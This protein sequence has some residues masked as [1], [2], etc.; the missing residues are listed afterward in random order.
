[1]SDR[2]KSNSML[3]KFKNHVP[4]RQS[5]KLK[6]HRECRDNRWK[7]ALVFHWFNFF[8]L[9][10][11]LTDR[12]NSTENHDEIKMIIFFHCDLRQPTLISKIKMMLCYLASSCRVTSMLSV[13]VQ[14]YSARSASITHG[15]CFGKSCG[16]GIQTILK[17]TLW[18]PRFHS[19]F[20][21][22]PLMGLLNMSSAL[23]F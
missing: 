20:I 1:M 15:K 9:W 21:L 18:S 2:G 16:T 7:A 19:S 17:R 12:G 10:F 14:R 4:E 11:S 13:C 5:N 8:S 6:M 23:I 3:I 22:A